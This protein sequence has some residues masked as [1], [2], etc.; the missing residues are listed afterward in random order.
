MITEALDQLNTTA[1]GQRNINNCEVWRSVPMHVR[2]GGRGISSF[3][4]NAKRGVRLDHVPQPQT[5][6][7]LLVDQKHS[8]TIFGRQETSLALVPG[9]G[10]TQPGNG[11]ITT[12]LQRD[13]FEVVEPKSQLAVPPSP[14]HKTLGVDN[15]GA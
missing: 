14:L 9:H 4:N 5:K 2:N 3:S 15:T 8:I 1:T 7:W 13:D 10:P 6:N 12:R 11:A